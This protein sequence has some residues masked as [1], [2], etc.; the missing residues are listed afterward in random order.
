MAIGGCACPSVRSRRPKPMSIAPLVPSWRLG[1]AF[2]TVSTC[3][4]GWV[5]RE[6]SDSRYAK[7]SRQLPLCICAVRRLHTLDLFRRRALIEAA[8]PSRDAF[9]IIFDR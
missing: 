2:E 9:S 1:G 4:P 8:A 5:S 7:S 3:V 6:P